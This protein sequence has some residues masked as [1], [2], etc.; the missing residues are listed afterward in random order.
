MS[1]FNKINLVKTVQ[2][3]LGLKVDGL[4]GLVTWSAIISKLVCSMDTKQSVHVPNTIKETLEPN[5]KVGVSDKAYNLILKYE[6]GGG[7]NY[8]NKALKC[9]TYPGGQ[10]GVT[11][12]I[13]YDLGYNTSTQFKNDWMQ[14]LDGESYNLLLG[15]IGKKSADAKSCVPQVKNISVSW[16]AAESVFTSNTLPR[17]IGE[18]KRA[19]PG[20]DALH[21]DAFGALVSLVFNRGGSVVGASRVEMNNIRKAIKGEIKTLNLYDYIAGQIIAMKR[22]WVG[23]GLDGLLTRRDEEARLVKSCA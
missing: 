16:D 10:S 23:K 3:I 14:H 19:F 13:G 18:T 17:F 7:E 11:I 1:E 8:Y 6:V 12:G 15:T 5:L 9:P 2:S 21:P 22:L 20:S 4:D